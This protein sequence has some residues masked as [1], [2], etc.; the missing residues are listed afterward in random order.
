VVNQLP[1]VT[2]NATQTLACLNDGLVTLNGMPSGGLYG[3]TG[4]AGNFFDPSI[5]A[6]NYYSNYTYTDVNGCTAM[7]SVNISVSICTG[8]KTVANGSSIILYPNPAIDYFIVNSNS[9]SVLNLIV[10]DALGKLILKQTIGSDIEKINTSQFAKGI[11]FIQ[12][13]DRN[14]PVYRGKIIKN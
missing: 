8:I 6:G 14:N 4:V 11:Y 13:N 3:G 1:I 7:D 10:T 5:G 2:V 12:I 9:H